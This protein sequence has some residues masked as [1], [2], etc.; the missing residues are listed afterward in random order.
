MADLIEPNCYNCSRR[1][2]IKK[3]K[4]KKG[5]NICVNWSGDIKIIRQQEKELKNE[6]DKR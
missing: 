5:Q 3:C 2:N 1:N 6:H 4:K